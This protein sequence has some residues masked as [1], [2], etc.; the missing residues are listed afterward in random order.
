MGLPSDVY[1]EKLEKLS[2]NLQIHRGGE[3][4]F[5]SAGSGIAPLIEAIDSIGRAGLRGSIVADK[6]VGRAA[7]L[8]AAY[9]EA[10]EVHAALISAGAKEVL[11]GHGIGF[12]F[13]RETRA[14]LSRDGA[15]L[16]PFER[17]VLDVRDPS[18]AYKRIKAKLSG[19]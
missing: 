4:I 9:M 19:S 7:A 2:L 6:I 5:S 12:R 1:L 15:D 8:M 3:A 18:E 10:S 11:R 17:L 13:S 16:C 14:I